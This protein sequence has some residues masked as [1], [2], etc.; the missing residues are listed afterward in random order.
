MPSWKKVITSGS[1]AALNS[2]NVTTSLTASG[3]IYPTGLGVDRQIL[4]TNGA[5]NISFGY[6]E[7]IV[8]IVKNV[9]GGTLQKG[10]PVHATASGAMG[11]VVGII[12]ASASDASTMPATFVLNE[13]L[14]DGDEGEALSAGFIQGVNT[15]AFE[16]G[17]IVYVGESGGYTGTKP[18]GSNLIQNLG[19][20]TKVGLTNGAGYVLGAGRSND[21]PNIQPG[22]VWVGNS[23]S[24][25]TPT[26]TSSIQNV[27]SA[28]F[29]TSASWAPGGGASFPYTGS[30]EITGS[31]G[32]TGSFSVL[33]SIDATNK[34]LIGSGLVPGSTANSVNW[35]SRT[36]FDTN[37]N[38]SIRWGNLRTMYDA[39][40]SASIDWN[41]RQLKDANGID[42]VNWQS[43]ISITGSN[44]TTGSVEVTGSFKVQDSI[45]SSN[46]WLIGPGGIPGSTATAVAWSDRQLLNSS[47]ATI[48]NWETGVFTGTATSASFAATASFINPLNQSM[49]I[50]GSLRG[51]VSALSILSNTASVDMVTNNFFTLTLANGASTNINPTNINPGQTVN[52]LVTQGS[53]GTG[54]VTFPSLVKQASGSLYTGS[55]VANAVDIV[56]MIAF[57]AT[58][59]YVSSIRNMI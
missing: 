16:V 44:I 52:I 47:G 45:D 2:L 21:L 27:V 37:G 13:T 55:A 29:A 31:L 19:I 59:V 48:V 10:T 46:K 33:D 28:S 54:T 17:Q 12:A 6:A 1:D 22:Y 5:G 30:A 39:N 34:I 40:V 24:V 4:K 7:E 51:Q 20:V 57:D 53:A 8:A 58:N 32:V 42:I 23:N 11:N 38:F 35:D 14:N 50:T 36:L 15:A 3:N 26:A 9:S 25:P 56:T 49:V 43:G 18:T 41:N